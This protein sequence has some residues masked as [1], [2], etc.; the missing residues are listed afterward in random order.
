M[1]RL[2]GQTMQHHGGV[3]GPGIYA[4]VGATAL[5]A[6]KAR[7]TI[8]LAMILMETTGEAAFSLPIFLVVLVARWVGDVF[9]RGI[10]DM[11]IIDLKRIPLLETD[12]EDCMIDMQAR[13]V[14][15][16]DIVSIK[17]V[18]EVGD[19]YEKL[20]TCT[21]SGFPVLRDGR[22]VG[23]VPREML[24]FLLNNAENY[25]ILDED[26]RKIIPYGKFCRQTSLSSPGL[27]SFKHFQRIVD[28]RIDLTPYMSRCYHTMSENATVYVC[29]ELF[30]GQGLRWLFVVGED[31]GKVCGVITRKDLILIEDEGE[32]CMG[33]ALSEKTLEPSALQRAMSCSAPGLGGG[34]GGM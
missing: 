21:H 10:Y 24:N 27:R 3:A 29:Y 25:G 28:K 16:R 4:L 1:G 12:P 33:P 15:N 20:T 9:G 8:S 7:I 13:E 26:D 31:D 32:D 5:L 22:I 2:F 30:R 23:L 17:E 34:M 19:L 6:G 11:H 14:M 18:E